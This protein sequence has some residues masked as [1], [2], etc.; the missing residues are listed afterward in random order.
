MSLQKK[1]DKLIMM[2]NGLSQNK[3]LL[4]DAFTR[5]CTSRN[6]QIPYPAVQCMLHCT[7]HC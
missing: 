7:G 2:L 5:K 6:K 4:W 1:D 3:K